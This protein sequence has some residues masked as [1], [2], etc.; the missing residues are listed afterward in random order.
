MRNQKNYKQL[1][2][3][4]Q[5]IIIY[6]C[7]QPK[8]REYI[9]TLNTNNEIKTHIEDL[10][11]LITYQMQRISKQESE[12]VSIKHKNAWKHY[13]RSFDHYSES[14]R[15]FFTTEEIKARKC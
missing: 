5:N 1:N 4:E 14:D 6:Q 11:I 3:K 15:R 7:F 13:D 8:V 9:A 12:I 2:K 10:Y